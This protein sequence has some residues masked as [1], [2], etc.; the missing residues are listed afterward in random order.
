MPCRRPSHES[1]LHPGSGATASRSGRRTNPAAGFTIVELLVS[2]A[3][4]AVLISL[5]LPV[6]GRARESARRTECLSHLRSLGQAI[7]MYRGANGDLLP[8][9][10]RPVDARLGDLDPLPALA[11]YLD[12]PVPSL[13]AD[14]RVI[15]AP[16]YLC[17]SDDSIGPERGCSF[18]YSP[19]DLMAFLP[20]DY[21]QRVITAYLSRD[22]SVVIMLDNRPR[23]PGHEPRIP[24]S[25]CNI[26]RLDGGAEAGYAGLSINPRR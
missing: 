10:A 22:P 19:I 1:P 20:R 13:D 8:Y 25:G 6:I 5:L 16:P 3:V 14:G 12:A 11:A 18:Y 23:H 7:A 15:S 21:A 4:V 24:L 26:L 17:P 9:A 2:I